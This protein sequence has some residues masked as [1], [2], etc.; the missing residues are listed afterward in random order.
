M[1]IHPMPDPIALAIGPLAIRW[2]GL[3]YLAAFVQF[4]LLGRL[5]IRQPHIAR[6]GW[7]TA[8]IDDLLFYGVL[9]VVIGGRLGEVVFYHPGYY[10]ANP[11]EIIAIWKGG[12][13]FHGGFLGVLLA[14]WLW[15]RRH[16]R[17]WMDVMDFIAPLVPLGYAFGRM[18]NFINAELPGR[19]ADADLP[20]A[21]IWPNVD[22]LP[23][24]PSP[25]YQALVDGVLLFIL[26]WV[27]ARK[28]R[29]YLAVSGVFAAG[30]GFAR[31]F[32]EFY[33]M[34]D[35]EIEFGSWTISAGQMLSLPMIVLG[36]VLLFVAYRHHSAAPAESTSI[37]PGQQP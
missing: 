31:F 13:S 19:I 1:L 35:Y 36:V 5:R 20:W 34:P 18:G 22:A 9:G 14:M 33:R 10:L 27:F 2:Y 4:L 37:E 21:M 25:I 16:G 30:Y 29:P 12:M 23:R 28:A 17:R 6:D 8:D 7:T 3:M 24:H 15:A 32:T 26:L 11:D